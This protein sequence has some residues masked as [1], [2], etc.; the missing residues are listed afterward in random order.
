MWISE[1]FVCL[2]VSLWCIETCSYLSDRF[3][4]I[5]DNCYVYTWII[6]AD[7]QLNFTYS[8]VYVTH[9]HS[10]HMSTD[11]I[12]WAWGWWFIFQCFWIIIIINKYSVC[13]PVI[14]YPYFIKHS[15][16]AI[17]IYAT[18]NRA[19]V[20]SKSGGNKRVNMPELLPVF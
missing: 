17:P 20:N 2:C 15:S 7:H 6:H 5:K 16:Y 18:C 13:S 9:S 8:Y 12:L 14:N 3:V 4:F 10:T 19:F 11:Q 1:F